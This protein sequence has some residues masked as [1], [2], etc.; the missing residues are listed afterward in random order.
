MYI[1]VKNPNSNNKK[2]FTQSTVLQKTVCKC[3]GGKAEM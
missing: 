1:Y 2:T 3:D